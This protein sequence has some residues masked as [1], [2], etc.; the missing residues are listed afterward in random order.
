MS[1]AVTAEARV[2][3]ATAGVSAA[4]VTVPV[5]AMER[6]VPPEGVAL[7]VNAL[8]EGVEVVSRA[9]SK[10]TAS[11][12]PFTV[13]LEND[14]AVASAVLLVTVWSPKVATSVSLLPCSVLP[15]VG[16]A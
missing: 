14:G 1:A 7:T 6:A 5:P 11:V 10:V 13:A 12:A 3:V 2:T 15:V 4:I 8:P 9:S 16:L